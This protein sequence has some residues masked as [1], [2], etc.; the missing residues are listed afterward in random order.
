M[1][2]P[3]N[4]LDALLA[5][6][7]H[8]PQVGPIIPENENKL[9]WMLKNTSPIRFRQEKQVISEP[10]VAFVK[11]VG[12]GLLEPLTL[13]GLGGPELETDTTGETIASVA[14]LFAGVGISWI[15]IAKGA[16][17]VTKGAF[18]AA[19]ASG[20]LK[21]MG[22][23]R[24]L[25]PGAEKIAKIALAGA[26]FETGAS[27]NLEEVP[28]RA[29]IGAAFG[30]TLEALLVARAARAGVSQGLGTSTPAVNADLLSIGRAIEL[31]GAKTA[32]EVAERLALIGDEAAQ[33]QHLG[34]LV[35][36]L[37]SPNGFAM[38]P[39]LRDPQAWEAALKA[40]RPGLVTGI[41]QTESGLF[42]VM[43]FDPEASYRFL[44]VTKKEAG[45][46]QKA[47]Q[48]TETE[49]VYLSS[50]GEPL[51]Y[52]EALEIL[53]NPSRVGEIAAERGVLPTFAGLS[54]EAVPFKGYVFNFTK[55]GALEFTDE[56]RAMGVRGDTVSRWE[57]GIWEDI[58]NGTH[59]LI[60]PYT[61]PEGKVTGIF[62][63]PDL[64]DVAQVRIAAHELSHFFTYGHDLS[65]LSGTPGRWK[66]LTEIFK[67]KRG[68]FS[69]SGALLN[70]G[71]IAP[72]DASMVEVGTQ[73]M[74][75]KSLPPLV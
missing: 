65:S 60:T 18:T 61:G 56:L 49:L 10:G 19:R 31:D 28:R 21:G 22:I 26:A 35:A 71:H 62:V 47:A 34:G 52:T 25:S 67:L 23:T 8:A 3:P 48:T 14:G 12:T 54:D 55:E 37:Q 29:V 30:G 15:P 39:G 2:R 57:Y 73:F 32:E 40:A 11:G 4:K 58:E 41:R 33:Y 50:E 42:E 1:S 13:L 24:A 64:K 16:G 36:Q 66:S 51:S 70:T 43:Q 59:G 20:I 27:T 75:L 63:R 69:E 72:A 44:R 6:T 45:A 46:A 9:D 38:S 5:E 17:V 53:R 7:G 74:D 68:R